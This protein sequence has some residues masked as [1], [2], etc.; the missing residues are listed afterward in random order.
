MTKYEAFEAIAAV[1]DDVSWIEYRDRILTILDQIDQPPGEFSVSELVG[2]LGT[3]HY[4]HLYANGC[5]F[6]ASRINCNGEG[7]ES[8]R[9]KLL[10]LAK[11]PEPKT[12]PCDVPIEWLKLW[13]RELAGS[14][15]ANNRLASANAKAALEKAGV[16]L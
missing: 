8:L 12:A 9:A 5:W 11:P 15:S 1:S 10:E 3:G 6:L 14:S 2:S 16:K 7:I 13:V 4:V